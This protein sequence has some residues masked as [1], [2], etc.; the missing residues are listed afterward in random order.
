M[1]KIVFALLLL[2]LTSCDSVHDGTVRSLNGV[3]DNTDTAWSKTREYLWL[4]DKN[5]VKK[6]PEVSQPRYCYRTYQDIICYGEPLV[7]AENRLVA[8]QDAHA[9]AG[10]VLAPASQKEDT[11]SKAVLK[12][13]KSVNVGSPPPV[14][15]DTGAAKKQLKEIIFEPSELNPRELVPKATQ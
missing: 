10:Y 14:A 11:A 7:G 8:Y 12:P 5:K 13:I 3:E 4:D 2:S 15:G 1:N 6:A 9:H